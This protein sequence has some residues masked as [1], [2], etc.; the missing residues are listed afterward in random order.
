MFGRRKHLLN[1]LKF[2]D[3]SIMM[4][5]LGLAT[6]VAYYQVGGTFSFAEFVHMRVEVHN[7]FILAGFAGLWHLS[8]R[9]FGSYRSRRLSSRRSATRDILKAASVGTIIVLLASVIFRIQIATP[10]FLA[11]FWLTS[12]VLLAGSRLALRSSS[13]RSGSEAA[14]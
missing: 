11:T 1:A 10:A 14:T 13:R 4:G 8:F 9:F 12:S 2:L 7:L 5:A 6:V 3:V